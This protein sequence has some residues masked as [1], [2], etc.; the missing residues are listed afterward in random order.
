M[1][2]FF[3]IIVFLFISLSLHSQTIQSMEFQ[4]QEISDILLALAESTET[5]ILP[6]ETITG[7]V[8][9]YFSESSLQDA[10]DIFSNTF[11]LFYE[12]EGNIIKV[13]K[14]KSSYNSD[15][16]KLSIKANEVS[17]IHIIKNI[18]NKIGKTIL[19]DNLPQYNLSLDIVELPIEEVLNICIKRFPEY[20]IES[21]GNYFYIQRKDSP[22]N[23]QNKVAIKDNLI[24]S[25]DLYTLNLNKGRF[26][27]LITQL[28]SI[29]K[30]EY[31]IFIQSDVMLEN[32]YF[33]NKDFDTMLKLI[34]E[35]ANADFVLKDNIYY[36]FDLQKKNISG[37]L[38][39]TEVVTLSWLQ[40][41]E[42]PSLFP[43]DLSNGPNI[44]VD[45]N[46]NSLLLTGTS[47]EITA[48]K[49]FISIIDV[50][51]N[52]FT[53]SKVDIKYLDAN[54]LC[55]L[56]PERMVQ[57]KPLVIPGSNSILLSGSAE[58]INSLEK[59]ISDVDS[60]K[61]GYPVQL[62]YIK[63]ETLLKTLPPSIKSGNLVDS[64]YP[65]LVFYTGSEENLKLFLHELEAIDKPQPQI[66]YQLLVIQYSK[67]KG[68][69]ITPNLTVSPVDNTVSPNFIF[70]GELN[71]ILG[72]S[73]DV[74]SKFGYQ[75]AASLNIKIHE[76][77]ANV[78]TD[79]TLTGI[80]GQDIKFQNTDT[81]R[82]IEYDYD[83]S[84]DT[85]RRTSTTQQITSGLIVNLN[86]WVSGDNMITMTVN[87][88]I[89]KQNSESGTTNSKTLTT[90]PSTS[91]RVVTTQVRAKSGEPIIISG[92]IKEDES[93]T[94]NRTPFISKIPVLGHLFKQSSKNKEKTEIVIYIVPH[95]IQEY[96]KSDSEIVNLRRYY[97]NFVGTTNGKNR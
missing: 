12:Q 29:E 10:L 67:G 70:N 90:L 48:L 43:P 78:F 58:N 60:K 11:H 86:G 92:L 6:D 50:P 24:K 77:K 33:A 39:S 30:K 76:N 72:L 14:I 31:S 63:T 91:E 73:F 36:L 32:L 16:Q 79:T 44:K 1:K 2:K 80:S 89:S 71:N 20:Q 52:G 22:D 5:S 88:T 96:S 82:Y 3:L 59:F 9:F 54:D 27:E 21:N 37:K 69:S 62:K 38:K 64:G 53:Y 15:T 34:L 65:N 17:L 61:S 84:S 41:T 19:Y 57:N 18:S 13:S 94:V 35:H 46:S 81:Y 55:K 49:K 40:A 75:F 26:L 45:K 23:V 56:I 47:D 93:D 25:N 66:K 51:L 8:S 68:D 87:A 85:T 83:S 95:L 4:R 42:V 28:F 7:K 97:E 74:I